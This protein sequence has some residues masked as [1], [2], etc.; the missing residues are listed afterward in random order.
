M[1]GISGLAGHELIHKNNAIH[2]AIGTFTFTKILYSH[3]SLEHNTGHHKY[4]ATVDD[5]ATARKGEYFYTFGIRSAVKGFLHSF[6]HE[7]TRLKDK[8]EH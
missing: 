6:E 5:A 8:F 3:F 7:N 2:K 4:I 1:A